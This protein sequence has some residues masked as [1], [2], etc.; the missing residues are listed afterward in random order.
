MNS[1]WF[2]IIYIY[3]STCLCFD[4]FCFFLAASRLIRIFVFF[5]LFLL[6]FSLFGYYH[7]S[8][9]WIIQ[10]QSIISILFYI[11][12][13]FYLQFLFLFLPVAG[14]IIFLLLKNIMFTI[15]FRTSSKKPFFLVYMFLLLNLFKFSCTRRAI[16]TSNHLTRLIFL[17][18][19]IWGIE[20]GIIL[21]LINNII[22]ISWLIDRFY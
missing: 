4:L 18:I 15:L 9:H 19:L 16:S 21:I 7:V 5:V 2:V 20:Y 6:W 12:T 17:C 14:W 1:R 11:A 8:Q 22:V 13:I 10:I 3:K